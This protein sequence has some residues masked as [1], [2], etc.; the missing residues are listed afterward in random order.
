VELSK[1]ALVHKPDL[2]IWPEAAVPNVVRYDPELTYPAITNLVQ[3]YKIWL[4]L[5][6]D[7][8]D[9]DPTSQ[10]FRLYNSSFLVN[11]QGEFVKTYR[12]RRLVM[13]G[14][15]VPFQPYLPFLKWFTPTSEDF[16]CGDQPVSFSVEDLNINTS[17]LI[18][19]EDVFPHQV[20]EH[21]SAHTSF[22]VNITNDGWFKESAAQWQHALN[23]LF[24]AVENRRP[25]IRCANNGLTCWI[26][27][28]GR[29]HEPFIDAKGTIYG[30]GYKIIN[31]EIPSSSAQ[32]HATFY[33]LHG[34][35]F[36]WI[37]IFFCLAITLVAK[38][39]KKD[40]SDYPN[41][42]CINKANNLND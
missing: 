25:L 13:F 39:A 2:L 28:Q 34:D 7:D 12:K 38:N 5:G 30:P 15:Y 9:P 31:L 29:I 1:E 24:R 16:F 17:V 36:G 32:M 10:N 27:P 8:A 11:P 14:E 4:I 40:R 3:T 42:P 22:L 37:C 18:C 21:V 35:L 19:F 23:A 6:A 26:D 20:P 41:G 33:Q